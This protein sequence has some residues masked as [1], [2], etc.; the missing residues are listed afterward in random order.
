MMWSYQ[1]LLCPQLVLVCF[2]SPLQV[3]ITSCSHPDRQ[4]QTC[5]IIH[6]VQMFPSPPTFCSSAWGSKEGRTQRRGNAE[7]DSQCSCLL[8]GTL[9]SFTTLTAYLSYKC[10]NPWNTFLWRCSDL[11]LIRLYRRR[12]RSISVLTW[13]SQP[14]LVRRRRRRSVLPVPPLECIQLVMV[15]LVE[16]GWLLAVP[17]ASVTCNTFI[18]AQ[19]KLAHWDCV[20]YFLRSKSQPTSERSCLVFN[21]NVWVCAV[22]VIRFGLTEGSADLLQDATV[23]LLC[24]GAAEIENVWK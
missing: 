19:P 23:Q 3:F 11:Q 8:A 6:C 15:V 5:Q 17:P 13:L 12:R 7:R 9:E 10:L 18:R 16:P 21:V 20:V 22:D 24:D 1:L 4:R 14:L 2:Q